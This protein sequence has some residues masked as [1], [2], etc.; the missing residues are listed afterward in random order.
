CSSV[1]T[2]PDTCLGRRINMLRVDVADNYVIYKKEVR[3]VGGSSKPRPG[4]TGV[5]A[6]KDARTAYTVGIEKAFSCSRV[7]D[8]RIRGIERHRCDSDIRHE[9]VK[10]RPARS[11]ISRFPNAAC[12]TCRVHDVRRTRVDDQRPGPATD[13]TWTKRLPRPENTARC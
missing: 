13:V 5:D 6:F 3:I 8:V 10:R 9:I 7:D 4:R 1:E 2:S 11:A 12:H